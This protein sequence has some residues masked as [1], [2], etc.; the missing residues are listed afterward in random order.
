MEILKIVVR[1]WENLC[2]SSVH[3]Y[4]SYNH[5]LRQFYRCWKKKCSFWGF[6]W[7][8]GTNCLMQG[9]FVYKDVDVFDMAVDD[10]VAQGL[11]CPPLKLFLFYQV[12]L[13]LCWHFCNGMCC[14]PQQRF[15]EIFNKNSEIYIEIFEQNLFSFRRE[16][17]RG[18]DIEQLMFHFQKYSSSS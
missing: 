15:A 2:L 13:K 9:V 7:P 11:P 14:T 3:I 18:R 4:G 17:G 16:G 10:P 1:W 6:V 8:R 5:Y 12:L